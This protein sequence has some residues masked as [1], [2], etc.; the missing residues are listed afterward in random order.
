[1]STHATDARSISPTYPYSVPELADML[2]TGPRSVYGAIRSKRLRAA[3]I[4]DRGDLR[5]LG[6]WAL[7]YLESL[8][9]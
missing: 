5:I 7:E 1:M 8:A 3:T 9:K 2:N 6:A 4:D